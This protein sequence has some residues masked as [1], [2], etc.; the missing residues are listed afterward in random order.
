MTR[1]ETVNALR[2]E[3]E[4]GNCD[5]SFALDSIRRYIPKILDYPESATLADINRYNS[6]IRSNIENKRLQDAL[7]LK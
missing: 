4:E 2:K 1:T 3:A 7:V 5:V 6:L